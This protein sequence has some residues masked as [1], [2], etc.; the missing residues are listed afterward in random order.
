VRIERHVGDYQRS[1]FRPHEARV[2]ACRPQGG[3]PRPSRET[4]HVRW[5]PLDRIPRTLFP[6]Y[7]VPLADA[8]A[9][10]VEPAVRHEH[11]GIAA[12][13]AGMAIDLRM[14]LSDDRAE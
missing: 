6:W 4:P 5:F 8:L 12:I 3:A 13:L 14:R 7:R 11:Q 2:F 9:E 1:G 10:R